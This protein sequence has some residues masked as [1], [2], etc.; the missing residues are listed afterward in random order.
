MSDPKGEGEIR[1]PRRAE[2]AKYYGDGG[3]ETGSGEEPSQE[4]PST[5]MQSTSTMDINSSNFDADTFTQRLI[6]QATL[7]QLMAQ[8]TEVQRQVG[9]LDSD[10]QTLVYENYNKFIAA[11]DTIKKMRVDFR[12]MEDQMDQLADKMNNISDFSTRVA[13]T[14]QDRRKKI[15]QLS[16]THALLKKLQFLFEL[17]AKLKECIAEDDPRAGVKYYV[18]AQKVLEQ[19]EHMPSFAGIKSDCDA[20]MVELQKNLMDKLKAN[21]PDAAPED[22]SLYV[23]LLLQLQESPEELCEAYLGAAN[24]KLQ[25]PLATLKEQVEVVSGESKT[26]LA[27]TTSSD[28]PSDAFVA[29]MDI[30]EFVDHGCNHFVSDLCLIIAAY[31]ETFLGPASKPSAAAAES[32]PSPSSPPLVDR[33]MAESKLTAFVEEKHGIFFDVVRSRFKLEKKMEDASIRVRA[34]DRFHRR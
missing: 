1:R 31:T 16:G 18:R 32:S 12:A 10:M 17:P 33:T 28:R 5:S 27:S 4:N 34:L 11:T 30:L 8:E 6:N 21:D 20:I 3:G 7:S 23:E 9:S 15:Q 14:L 25:A 22:L 19:Y 2:L 13:D 24:V 26:G 29:P